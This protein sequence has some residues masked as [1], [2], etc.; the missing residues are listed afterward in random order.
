MNYRSLAALNRQLIGWLGALPRDL[1]LIV[2]IPR[3]GLIPANLLSLH[4][5]IPLADLDG[6]LEGRVFGLG[7]RGGRND[8]AGFLS[9]PRKVLV[10][11]DSLQ[12]GR[13]MDAARRRIAAAKLPHQIRYAAVY[14]TPGK[15]PEVDFFCELVPD[16][17]CFEWNIMHH[18]FIPGS[19]IDLDGVL[20]REPTDEEND[21]GSVYRRFVETTEP[22]LIP[23]VEVGWI[24]TCR[25][26][27]YRSLTEQWLARHGVKYK[28]L[29]MMNFPTKEARVASG[30]HAAYKAK[31]YRET[32]SWLFIE[33]S[34]RQAADIA[35]L[36][37]KPV[38]CTENWEML[39]PGA[40]ALGLRHVRSSHVSLSQ[41]IRNGLSSAAKQL[42][43]YEKIR[44]SAVYRF[45]RDRENR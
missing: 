13:E 45:F 5:N 21:D 34:L 28:N 44:R 29:S 16:P 42:G 4:L 36:S 27:K 40:L 37:G 32:D 43:L 10:L 38:L 17:R 20:C 1:D 33:S 12:S 2:G 11:D 41:R 8:P 6:F 35:A 26:E 25:L 39:Q 7:F 22:L 31:I 30:S 3:S 14:V 9:K 23:T 19:C 15:E 24:V 18:S